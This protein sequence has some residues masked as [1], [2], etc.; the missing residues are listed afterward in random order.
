M[1][2]SPKA[3]ITFSAREASSLYL[4]HRSRGQANLIKELRSDFYTTVEK[5]E[6]FS[7]FGS[8]SSRSPAQRKIF[9]GQLRSIVIKGDPSISIKFSLYGVGLSQVL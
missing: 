3:A 2:S 7:I 1:A 6:L 5:K 4:L 9:R 8:R